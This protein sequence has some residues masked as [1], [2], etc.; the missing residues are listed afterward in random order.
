MLSNDNLPSFETMVAFH[1]RDPVGFEQFRIETLRNAIDA[2]APELRPSL[3]RTLH[4][5]EV[6]RDAAKSPLEAAT[7]TFS[8]MCESLID[9]QDAWHE[10]NYANA[11]LQTLIVIDELKKPIPKALPYDSLRQDS[12]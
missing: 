1:Q 3:C 5:I 7:R 6:V 8:L 11:E 2:L 9:L 10:I 12:Q 4:T